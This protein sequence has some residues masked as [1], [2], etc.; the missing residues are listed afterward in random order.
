V[1]ATDAV[2]ERAIGLG[3]TVVSAPADRAGG[4]VRIASLRDPQGA[5]FTVGSYDP[6]A[7]SG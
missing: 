6:T 5:E 7:A 3:G 1:A 4:V 2:V